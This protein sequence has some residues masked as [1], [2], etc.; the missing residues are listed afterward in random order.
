MGNWTNGGV[1][2]RTFLKAW[3]NHSPRTAWVWNEY[4]CYY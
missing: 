2:H 1:N 3:K 4:R